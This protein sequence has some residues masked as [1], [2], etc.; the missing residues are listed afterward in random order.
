MGRVSGCKLL[1]I[2]LTAIMMVPPGVL[3]QTDQDV[4]TVHVVGTSRIRGEDMSASREEA[5]KNSLVAAVSRV[6]TDILP[7]ETVVGYFQSLAEVVFSRTDQFVRDYKVLTEST[8]ANTYRLLVQANVSVKRLKE[9][10][11]AAGIASGPQSYPRVLF[12]IAE[13]RVNDPEPQYWWRGGPFFDDLVS[14]G[15][16]TQE[17]SDQGFILIDPSGAKVESGY[18]S[19]LSAAQAIALGQQLGAEVV[20]A[21]LALAEEAPNT[22][23]STIRSFRGSI[24]LQAF[25]VDD[26]LQMAQVQRTFLSAAGD[27]FVGGKEALF[28]AAT[29]AGQELAAQIGDAWFKQGEVISQVEVAVEGTGGNIASFVKFR[30]V[31]GTMSGVDGIQLKEMMQ[32]AAVL[33]VDYQGN[34][35]DLA[36]ALLLQSFDTFGINIVEV[37]MSHIRLQLVKP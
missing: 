7:Q 25:R 18:P 34:A 23:G 10:F 32:D 20:V 6:V 5:I 27:A 19:Q 9:T 14:T 17:M 31:L 24:A 13:Q 3:A 29:Q 30:G 33:S 11:K 8:Q 26:G 16:L 4:A 15:V 36:D 37:G 2:L 28:N 12:C 21:G 1:L 35:R 22:M